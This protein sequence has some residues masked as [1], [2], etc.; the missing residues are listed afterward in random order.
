LKEKVVDNIK[1]SVGLIVITEISGLGLVAVLRERGHFNFE[2]FTP[3]S[4]PGVCQVTVHGGLHDGETFTSALERETYEELGPAFANL[5]H[6]RKNFIVVFDGQG[7]SKRVK[8]YAQKLDCLCIARMRLAPDS[9]SIRIVR[10]PDVEHIVNIADFSKETG[11]SDRSV[12]AMFPDE[13]EAVEEA[14]HLFM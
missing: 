6:M 2:T 1:K 13:K 12:I 14:F 10:Q 11:V 4:W 3:E 9:G 5:S 8:T 7:E